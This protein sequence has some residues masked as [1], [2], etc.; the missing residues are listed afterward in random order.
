LNQ[1]NYS[2]QLLQPSRLPE[3]PPEEQAVIHKENMIRVL[4][5]GSSDCNFFDNS[6]IRRSMPCMATSAFLY[7][8][9][10]LKAERLLSK[11]E[12]E[13]WL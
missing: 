1:K 2:K 3:P 7:L 5:G 4:E 10:L 8:L 9:F 6:S 11:E 12:D 13:A